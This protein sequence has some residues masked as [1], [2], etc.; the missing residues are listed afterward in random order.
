MTQGLCQPLDDGDTA[1]PCVSA[2]ATTAYKTQNSKPT[3]TALTNPS[4]KVF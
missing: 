2:S 3:I 4:T 1:V